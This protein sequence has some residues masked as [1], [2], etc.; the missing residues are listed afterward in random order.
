MNAIADILSSKGDNFLN[1]QQTANDNFQAPVLSEVCS[2]KSEVQ[3]SQL[4][5][6]IY[7]MKD[8][9]DS[10]LRVLNGGE[11]RP[12]GVIDV[13]GSELLSTG[14]QIIEG[15][16]NG[17]K[18]VGPDGKEY[19]VPPNYASKSK[20]VEGDLLKLTIT[21]NGQFIYK[22]TGPVERE[23]RRGELVSDPV[24]DQWSVLADGR[25]YTIL[26]ASVTF[27]KGQAGDEVIFLVPKDANGSAA[28]G[29]VENIIH[30][31]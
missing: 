27:Y 25:T 21:R 4:K 10:M 2:L 29:A 8:Q 24:T 6:M 18:M 30:Q 3:I 14:E 15:V 28:W 22:Q 16:F 23:R 20:M 11:A 9:L 13:G 1:G 19:A 31:S 17:A 7:V 26:K 12:T 5:S